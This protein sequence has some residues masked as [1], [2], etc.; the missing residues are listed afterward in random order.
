MTTRESNPKI[1]FTI[2][3][4]Y[5]LLKDVNEHMNRHPYY[6]GDW[7]QTFYNYSKFDEDYKFENIDNMILVIG[8]SFRSVDDSW[9]R[10]HIRGYNHSEDNKNRWLSKGQTI[11]DETTEPLE[12]WTR[13]I[14]QMLIF[15][16][17]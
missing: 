15:R 3:K 6:P 9:C 2:D 7:L 8:D 12:F 11:Y 14:A 10:E 1:D 16:Y 17:G 4:K 5:K 13:F